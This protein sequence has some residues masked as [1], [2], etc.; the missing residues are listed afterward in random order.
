VK[1][2]LDPF[3]P[4]NGYNPN[5][6]STYSDKFKAQYFAAQAERMNNLIDSALQTRSL[7]D[8][9]VSRFTDDDDFIIARG[10]SS[11]GTGSADLI[12]LDLSLD[13]CTLKPQ[14]LLQNDGTIVTQIV[15]SVRVANPGDAQTNQTFNNGSKQLTVRS[16]LSLRAARATNSFDG[17]DL[18]SNNN[19]TDDQLKG[20]SVPLL[21]VSSGAHY[22]IPAGERH[23]NA[24]KSQDKDF[25]IIEGAA[26]T[27]PECVVCESFPGQYANSLTNQMNYMGN[28]VNQPGRF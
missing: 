8:A 26:H 4:K 23:Y 28:W 16:F 18:T 22:F 11:G 10:G 21:V 3:D 7:I 13:C 6:S 5:G 24:G 27:G 1:P 12:R 19:S 15:H 17:I 20:I 14:K 25:I 9:D 2:A